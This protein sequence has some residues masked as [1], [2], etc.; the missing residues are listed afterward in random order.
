MTPFFN[1]ILKKENK[2][3][4]ETGND[5][6]NIELIMNAVLITISFRFILYVILNLDSGIRRG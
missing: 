4:I 2:L 1:D 5:L 6:S 3:F